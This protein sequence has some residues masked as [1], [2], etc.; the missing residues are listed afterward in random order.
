MFEFIL[1][2]TARGYF[3][4]RRFMPTAIV[5]DAINTRRGLK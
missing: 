4:M 1:T 3:F 2:A 5:L